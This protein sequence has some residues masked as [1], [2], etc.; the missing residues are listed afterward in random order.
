MYQEDWKRGTNV[1]NAAMFY[2]IQSNPT[3]VIGKLKL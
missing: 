3:V 2:K 1:Y